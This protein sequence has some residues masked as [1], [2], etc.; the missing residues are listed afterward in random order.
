MT[1]FCFTH[2]LFLFLVPPPSL[3]C[4]HLLHKL[5]TFFALLLILNANYIPYQ[6]LRKK[7]GGKRTHSAEPTQSIQGVYTENI[8]LLLTRSSPG[9]QAKATSMERADKKTPRERDAQSCS[10]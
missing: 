2:S 10:L 1:L 7:L 6:A 3:L 8:K 9:H 5:A 4:L